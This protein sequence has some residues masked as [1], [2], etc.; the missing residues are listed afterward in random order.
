[1]GDPDTLQFDMTMS[2][3]VRIQVMSHLAGQVPWHTYVIPV[4]GE[5]EE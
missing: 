5:A 2:V 3:V 4:A 1:M